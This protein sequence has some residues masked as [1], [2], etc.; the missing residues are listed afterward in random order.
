MT[1]SSPSCSSAPRDRE[2]GG[3]SWARQVHSGEEAF[4]PS[5]PH[6]PLSLSEQPSRSTVCIRGIVLY[7]E[8]Q[9]QVQDGWGSSPCPLGVFSPGTEGVSHVPN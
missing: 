5:H 4:P 1:H 8:L 9:G 3:R 7:R 2:C 6:S